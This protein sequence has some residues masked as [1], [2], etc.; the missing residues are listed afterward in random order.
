MLREVLE[1]TI[2][3]ELTVSPEE[4][5]PQLYVSSVQVS[6]S[7]SSSIPVHLLTTC[8][9]YVWCL[10]SDNT[11]TIMEAT[12]CIPILTTPF[13]QK[14]REVVAIAVAAPH[15]HVIYCLCESGMLYRLEVCNSGGLATQYLKI[16]ESSGS[17]HP[18]EEII[19][20][21]AF[22]SS[23]Q[24]DCVWVGTINGPQN[25]CLI[26][27][28]D[29]RSPMGI[30]DCVTFDTVHPPLCMLQLPTT[31]ENEI[32]PVW[33]GTIGCIEVIDTDSHQ[34]K[35]TLGALEIG[36]G[37]VVSLDVDKE[38]NTVWCLV[39][40]GPSPKAG[41]ILVFDCITQCVVLQ[42]STLPEPKFLCI[43]PTMQELPS[44][45]QH[46]LTTK[47]AKAGWKSALVWCSGAQASIEA[48][49][50]SAPQITAASFSRNSIGPTSLKL[51]VAVP[52]TPLGTLSTTP[53]PTPTPPALKVSTSLPPPS[54]KLN[55]TGMVHA[56]GLLLC[57]TTKG[58]TAVTVEK[59]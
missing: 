36:S 16:D 10:Y 47:P 42:A 7:Q 59:H 12:Q 1:A 23:S 48:F 21:I 39:S 51:T 45:H 8:E 29:A 31:R 43:T 46:L 11:I 58:I 19:C 14:R 4:T 49:H 40:Q 9:L 54:T 3:Q 50:H 24:R 20:S 44:L 26:N 5:L 22:V 34:L 17:S 18:E 41:L 57:S 35:A 38:S 27:L 28:R 52:P 32:P 15:S 56:S 53:E 13:Q 37:Q 6:G 33:V 2:T 25:C 55:L 30:Y